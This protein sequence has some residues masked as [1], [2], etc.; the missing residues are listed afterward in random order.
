MESAEW[1]DFTVPVSSSLETSVELCKHYL[2]F[3][4]VNAIDLVLEY[5]H[6]IAWSS[7]LEALLPPSHLSLLLSW[8]L[9][10]IAATVFVEKCCWTTNLTKWHAFCLTDCS[11]LAWYCLYAGP[12][13]HLFH[14]LQSHSLDYS[15]VYD[16]LGLKAATSSDNFNGA[17]TRQ[18]PDL[19]NL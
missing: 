17:F 1:Y 5:S 12:R 13:I 3:N 10:A 4:A 14:C 11:G 7:R 6:L 16:C 2:R 15:S 18:H 19:S 8:L 9:S